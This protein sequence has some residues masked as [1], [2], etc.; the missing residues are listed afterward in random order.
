M[1]IAFI[2]LSILPF[3]P[4]DLLWYRAAEELLLQGHQVLIAPLDWGRDN[5]VEYE[6]IARQGALIWRRPRHERSRYFAVRQWQKLKHHITDYEKQWARV[7]RFSP[8]LIVVNDP[9]TYYMVGVPGLVEYLMS[10][11]VQ[12]AT[13]SQYND[14]NT[15]LPPHAYQRARTLFKG[16][17]HCIFVSERNLHVARRQLCLDLANAAVFDNPPKPLK[18]R[19]DPI[20]KRAPGQGWQ[21]WRA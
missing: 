20:S 18:M 2:T 12:F 16:A 7:G 19:S 3:A 21:W 1:R 9:G 5:A 10:G 11:Q 14:E 8:D 6:L 4:N 13:I 15:S 17:R